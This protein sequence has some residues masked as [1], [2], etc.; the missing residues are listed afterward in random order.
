MGGRGFQI[1]VP[2]KDFL[3]ESPLNVT[4]KSTCNGVIMLISVRYK[5]ELLSGVQIDLDPINILF[6]GEEKR[7]LTWSNSDRDTSLSEVRG[8]LA[9]E[10]N[11]K[12]KKNRR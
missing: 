4:C 7:Q 2:T 6:K 9:F 8:P 5:C 1:P 3:S 10:R 12:L 11:I